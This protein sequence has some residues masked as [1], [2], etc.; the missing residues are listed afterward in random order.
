MKKFVLLALVFVMMFSTVVL[1]DEGD[2]IGIIK[3]V[4]EIKY[5]EEGEIAYISENDD[6]GYYVVVL[7]PYEVFE[8]E[9]DLLYIPKES[10]ITDPT[11]KDFEE[12][13]NYVYL[14]EEVDERQEGYYKIEKDEKDSLTLMG[15]G[16]SESF[17]VEK[18]KVEYNFEDFIKIAEEQDP[19]A[20]LEE[21]K[22]GH[23]ADEYVEKVLEENIMENRGEDFAVDEKATREEILLGLGRIEEKF[24]EIEELDIEVFKDL[25]DKPYGNIAAWAK[26][27]G[28]IKGY[29]D[30]QFKPENKV[31][32]EELATMIGRYIN[33]KNIPTTKMYVVFDDIDDISDWAMYGVQ[34]LGNAGMIEGREDGKFYPQD[35]ITR[36]EIAK[37]FVKL[38]E[39][40]EYNEK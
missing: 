11:E 23:W 22:D 29:L 26:E 27:E 4:D 28:I 12:Y 5:A 21:K 35:D 17:E 9:S 32:R 37:I 3:D 31:T 15:Y 20:Y 10:L 38:T 6:E 13:S 14:K 25:K 18:D 40:V 24:G 19:K 39:L 7:H 30:G 16:G 8:K 33:Y 1:A 36:G 34:T 2:R